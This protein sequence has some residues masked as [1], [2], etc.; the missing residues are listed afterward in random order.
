MRVLRVR[1]QAA[2]KI[3]ALESALNT[4]KAKSNTEV[5][6]TNMRLME[7]ESRL[8]SMQKSKSEMGSDMDYI[9]SAIGKID[10]STEFGQQEVMNL[11][12]FMQKTIGGLQTMMS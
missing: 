6:R 11:I 10:F 12:N 8:L 3:S 7:I 1:E 9:K 5:E 2:F 4:V